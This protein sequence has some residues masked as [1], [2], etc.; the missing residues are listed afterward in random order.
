MGADVAPFLCR[1]GTMSVG[2]GRCTSFVSSWGVVRGERMWYLFCVMVMNKIRPM[3]YVLHIAVTTAQHN[4]A[5]T[6]AHL[7]V[8]RFFT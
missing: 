8:H 1:H 6:T 4:T 5:V 3:P 2:S 7:F